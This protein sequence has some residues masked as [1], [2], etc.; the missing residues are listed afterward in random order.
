VQP[1]LAARL[2]L[3]VLYG[4]GDVDVVTFDAG[5]L[6]RLIQHAPGGADERPAGPILLVARLLADQHHGGA[7]GSLAEDGLRGMPPKRAAAAARGVLPYPAERL[8]LPGMDGRNGLVQR[9]HRQRSYDLLSGSANYPPGWEDVLTRDSCALRREHWCIATIGI[10]Y[11][12][13]EA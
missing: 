8:P 3:E 2:V 5:G 1:A 10:S 6:Q 12:E 11:E 13:S 9:R 4:V 7:R